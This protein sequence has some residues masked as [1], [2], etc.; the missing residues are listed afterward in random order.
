M[1]YL[2]VQLSDKLSAAPHFLQ[3]SER[4]QLC[5]GA[6]HGKGQHPV[7]CLQAVQTASKSYENAPKR[8]L[9]YFLETVLQP[10]DRTS[11]ELMINLCSFGESVDPLASAEC[12]KSAPNSLNHGM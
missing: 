3:N 10:A 2:T 1:L 9:G 12:Y 7:Q 4:I 5:A 8:A 6:P 11:R